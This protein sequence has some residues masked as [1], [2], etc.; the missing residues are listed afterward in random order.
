MEVVHNVIQVVIYAQRKMFVNNVLKAIGCL[1]I[2]V[3]QLVR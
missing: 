1:K 2:N 3:L